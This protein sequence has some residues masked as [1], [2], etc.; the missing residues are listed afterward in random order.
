MW[1]GKL[2][3][4]YANFREFYAYSDT[5]GLAERLGYDSAEDAWK[6][7]PKVQGSTNPDD[8][9]KACRKGTRY[10]RR[11]QRCVRIKRRK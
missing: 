4:Q 6:A 7:N 9:R 8:F 2:R 3:K 10:D 1:Q 11:Q 5:Y